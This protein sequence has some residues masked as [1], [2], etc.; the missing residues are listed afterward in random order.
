MIKIKNWRYFKRR[1]P[2]Y[3]PF[4]LIAWLIGLSWG[5]LI[6]IIVWRQKNLQI[7][8]QPQS[9]FPPHLNSDQIPASPS[10]QVLISPSPSPSPVF[11]PSPSPLPLPSP[12]PS[13]VPPSIP[14]TDAQLDQWFNQYSQEYGVEEYT[15]K[16]IAYCESKMN[17]SA[18]NGPYAGLFQFNSNTWASTRTAMAADPNA[19]LRFNAQESIR[20]AAWKIAHGG[21][22]AWPNCLP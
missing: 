10:P 19:D 21:Q 6:Q 12:S 18:V 2:S 8:F 17:P 16:Y 9:Y 7:I 14:V 22:N 20:T 15:L 13:P 3:L 11:F 1:F 5:I 4:F